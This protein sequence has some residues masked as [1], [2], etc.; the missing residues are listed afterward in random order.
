MDPALW[1]HA[2]VPQMDSTA[3]QWQ[4]SSVSQLPALR[5]G[6]RACLRATC[7]DQDAEDPVGDRIVLAVDELASNGLRHGLAPVT[8][9]IA[10]TAHG[11]LIDIS[12][13]SIDHG[14]QP[15]VGRD[16]ALGGMGLYLVAALTAGRGWSVVGK[17]KHVWACLPAA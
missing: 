15:A 16:R 5:A 2:P 8:A 1:P 3:W 11:W 4:V 14:P 13:R 6:L 12:D 9:R 17:D 7:N 10:E